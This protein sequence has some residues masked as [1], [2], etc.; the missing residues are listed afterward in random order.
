M[1]D[2]V[3]NCGMMFLGG[4]MLEKFDMFYEMIVYEEFG[5]LGVSGYCDGIGVGFVIGVLLVFMF[6]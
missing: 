4:L 3:D 5:W 1:K 2:C 6:V